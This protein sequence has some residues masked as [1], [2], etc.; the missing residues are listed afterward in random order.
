MFTERRGVMQ[1]QNKKHFLLTRERAGAIFF[2]LGKFA[3]E[4]ATTADLAGAIGISA[5]E[6]TLF[7]EAFNGPVDTSLLFHTTECPLCIVGSVKFM[8]KEPCTRRVRLQ[9]SVCQTTFYRED[10]Q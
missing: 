9:C 8:D 4:Q 5:E 6:M 7:K 10:A 1:K 2:L 3:L